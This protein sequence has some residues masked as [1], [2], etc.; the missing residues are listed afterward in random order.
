MTLEEQNPDLADAPFVSMVRITVPSSV[1]QLIKID[2]SL[3]QNRL[4]NTVFDVL[5]RLSDLVQ[6][7]TV[8]SYRTVKSIAEAR[9][10]LLILMKSKRESVRLEASDH[11]IKALD[12]NVLLHSDIKEV[13]EVE[14]MLLL[15]L[16]VET[17]SELVRVME[18]K[19]V[20]PNGKVLAD[21]EIEIFLHLFV[22]ILERLEYMNEIPS[23]A[24]YQKPS[25]R[26]M[27]SSISVIRELDRLAT[28]DCFVQYYVATVKQQVNKLDL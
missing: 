15:M 5:R 4:K 1:S 9:I 7:D 13:S 20:G 11:L 16:F 19:H 27:E 14:I 12:K 23:S 3:V 6:I 18:D 2:N 28:E 17:A 24:K 25:N 26:I 21:N 10:C 22:K 8:S